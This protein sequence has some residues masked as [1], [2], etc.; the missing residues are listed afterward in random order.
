MS[1]KSLEIAKAGAKAYSK[2]YP[3]LIVKV[4][5]KKGYKAVFTSSNWVYTGRVLEGFHTVITY[6]NGEAV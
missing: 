6:K 5:D 4:M 1:K 3:E 2:E